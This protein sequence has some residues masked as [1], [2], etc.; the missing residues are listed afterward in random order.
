MN[1]IFL[2]WG[3]SGKERKFNK[4]I[5]G[6]NLI[7][8]L[9]RAFLDTLGRKQKQE[10][11]PES[12]ALANQDTVEIISEAVKQTLPD[13]QIPAHGAGLVPKKPLSSNALMPWRSRKMPDWSALKAISVLL[14][15]A[16]PRLGRWRIIIGW[17]GPPWA[18]YAGM[19]SVR[20]Q[21]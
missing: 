7:L 6:L 11:P 17:R 13:K 3:R 4:K 20:L 15:Q 8:R 10:Q 9:I 14:I 16:Y 2:Q 19:G 18:L 12:F 1:E 5:P 21:E